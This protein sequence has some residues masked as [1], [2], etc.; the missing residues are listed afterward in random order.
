M[1]EDLFKFLNLCGGVVALSMSATLGMYT[2]CKI[3]KW[4]P[5]NFTVT[6]YRPDA[7]ND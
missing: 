4:A 2:V 3:A 7:D 6:I 5:I 1:V